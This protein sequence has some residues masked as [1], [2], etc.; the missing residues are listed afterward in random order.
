[1]INDQECASA[2]SLR[3]AEIERLLKKYPDINHD[4]QT[5]VVR[6]FKREATAL[7]VAML[8]GIDDL[9]P[10]YSAFR[11]DHLDRVSA[12]SLLLL[13]TALML[14]LGGLVWVYW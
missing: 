12:T 2:Q 9:K 8:S 10:G 7:D 3:R 14:G 4:E 1:M 5:I 13:S 11:K 6:W